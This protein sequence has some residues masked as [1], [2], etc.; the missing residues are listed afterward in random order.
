METMTKCNGLLHDSTLELG[1]PEI[2]PYRGNCIRYLVPVRH[3]QGWIEAPYRDGR[4]AEY[5]PYES[6]AARLV[7]L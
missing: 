1:E 7:L 6:V 2:C 5:A 3:G 4:C